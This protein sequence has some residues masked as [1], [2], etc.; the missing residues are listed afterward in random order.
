MNLRVNIPELKF[1]PL[2]PFVGAVFIATA[3]AGFVFYLINGRVPPESTPLPVYL[4][5]FFGVFLLYLAFQLHN[6]LLRTFMIM[7][8]ANQLLSWL[9]HGYDGLGAY[10]VHTAL[11]L[12]AGVLLVTA[13]LKRLSHR[14]FFAAFL[15]FFVFVIFRYVAI[16]NWAGILERIE[17]H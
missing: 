6:R 13:G 5:V 11:N 4:L 10:F 15:L 16:A 17:Y 14:A 3:L 7:L 9:S 8:F 2:A 1:L 12:L